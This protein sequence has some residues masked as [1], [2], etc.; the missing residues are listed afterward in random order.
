MYSTT[1][2]RLVAGT[3]AVGLL[4]GTAPVAAAAPVPAA[5]ASAKTPSLERSKAAFAH[6][7]R[8]WD[9]SATAASGKVVFSVERIRVARAKAAVAS[10][11]NLYVIANYAVGVR[12][13][14]LTV[15]LRLRTRESKITFAAVYQRW[16]LTVTDARANGVAIPEGWETRADRAKT[17][18]EGAWDSS[19][20]ENYTN[21]V[22][23]FVVGLQARI[24]ANGDVVVAR[25]AF[26]DAIADWDALI[27]RA[28]HYI[29]F[30]A[31]EARVER[32][33]RIVATSTNPFE[34][35][36]YTAGVRALTHIV[37]VRLNEVI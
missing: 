3:V 20:I 30:D 2:N 36:D 25:A 31:E 11:T 27:A 32:A 17:F 21:G 14:A 12:N 1:R 8:I 37:R 33:K 24:D 6:A 34:I 26:D 4:F 7:L 15:D 5:V 16:T 22:R 19:P 9:K 18:V 29:E 35:V 23:N 28:I 10:T 13:L